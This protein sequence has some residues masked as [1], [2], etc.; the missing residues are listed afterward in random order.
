MG[1]VSDRFIVL[2]GG[3][4]AELTVLKQLWELERRGCTFTIQSDGAMHIETAG[5]IGPAELA[6]LRSH[7]EMTRELVAYVPPS[8]GR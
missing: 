6:F 1:R 8:P 3:L 7:R 4:V 2:R 5:D